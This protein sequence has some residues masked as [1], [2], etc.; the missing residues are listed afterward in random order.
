MRTT[1]HA[2][3]IHDHIGLKEKVTRPLHYSGAIKDIFYA[4]LLLV[5]IQLCGG[6]I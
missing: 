5:Y 2:F 6:Q 1:S 4:V 3:Q